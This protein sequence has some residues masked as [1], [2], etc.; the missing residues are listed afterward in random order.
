MPIQHTIE[1]KQKAL[2]INLDPIIYGA[3]AE[4]GA[5]QEVARHFF[6]AGAAAGTIAKTMSAY[7]KKYSD[8]IYGAESHG[9]YVCESRLYKML[10]HEYDLMEERLRDE[11]PNTTFFA[12]ADTISAINFKKT[13]KGHG[14]MGLRFQLDSTQAPNDIVLHVKMMDNDNGLQQQAVGILGV[15]LI[16]ACFRYHNDV[17]MLVKSLLDG[18]RDRV[19]VDMLRIS[20]SHFRDIDN[21]V[22]CLKMVKYGLSAVTMFN[23]VGEPIHPSEVLYKQSLLVVRGSYRPTT[24]VNMDMI[25]AATEQF[26][27]EIEVDALRVTTLAEITLD[28]LMQD[29]ELDE[30]DFLDRVTLLCA[31]RQMVL[32]TNCEKHEKLIN[33]FADYRIPKLGLVVG[34]QILLNIVNETYYQNL[35]GSLLLAFGALFN[36]NVKMYI[37]PVRQSMEETTLMNC[38]NLPIPEG[39][40]FLYR[41]LLESKH[42]EDVHDVHPELLHIYSKDVLR[43]IRN[44]EAGWERLVPATVAKLIKD[45]CLFNY[46][47]QNIQIAY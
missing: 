2:E 42:I 11:R 19:E 20:G 38:S 45:Q 34:A 15:N 30:N 18:L 4:I 31:Q 35:H 6:R 17:D 29:G 22:I 26:K 25:K 8:D 27:Q 41:Y 13:N 33:Y 7:D 47:C 36:H 3:F 1:T 28:N 32:V 5:G 24:L 46:P 37:Y 21:R 44:D 23:H 10:T 43:M 14:W 12:F 9:R 39:I 40:K 16:Y